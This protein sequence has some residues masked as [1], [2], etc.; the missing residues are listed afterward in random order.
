MSS[1]PSPFSGSVNFVKLTFIK[2]AVRSG[3]VS[4]RKN[5]FFSSAESSTFGGSSSIASGSSGSSSSTSDSSETS[6]GS[7]FFSSGFFF[8]QQAQHLAKQEQQEQRFFLGTAGLGAGLGKEVG[9]SAKTSVFKMEVLIVISAL[10]KRVGSSCA[11]TICSQG[12]KV[13]VDLQGL[14][15]LFSM[16]PASVMPTVGC[17]FAFNFFLVSFG[18]SLIFFEESSCFDFAWMYDAASMS[19]FLLHDMTTVLP[20]LVAIFRI[21][22]KQD[23]ATSTFPMS[24]YWIKSLFSILKDQFFL[25]IWRPSVSK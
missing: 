21:P 18:S 15:V 4:L 3:V 20:L 12:T 2:Y 13:A 5:C 24:L 17:T 10:L 9:D 1:N 11:D 23:Q 19:I 14:T 16:S 6:S 22:L 8:L 7:S 25:L